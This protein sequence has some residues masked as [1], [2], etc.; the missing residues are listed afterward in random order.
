[1]AIDW[2]AFKAELSEKDKKTLEKMGQ[3]SADGI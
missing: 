3:E 1:M 2:D